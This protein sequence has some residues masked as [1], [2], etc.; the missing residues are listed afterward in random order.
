MARSLRQIQQELDQIKTAA[1]ELSEQLQEAYSRYLDVLSKSTQ[2]QLVLAGYHL[3]TQIYPETF[4]A[5]SLGQ[6][7]EMQQALRELGTKLEPALTKDITPEEL[8]PEPADLSMIAEMLKKLPLERLR[9]RSL[10]RNQEESTEAILETSDNTES[11]EPEEES[12]LELPPGIESATAIIMQGD[13]ELIV[14]DLQELTGEAL[15]ELA[16]E[17]E[18]PVTELDFSNPE[19]LVLWQKTLEKRIRKTLSTTSRQANSQLQESRI[20]PERLPAKLLD[21]ALKAGGNGGSKERSLPNIVNLTIE[22]DSRKKLKIKRSTQV[23][24]LRLKLSELEFA[25]PLLSSQRNAIRSLN[26]KVKQLQSVYQSKKREQAQAE[27]DA[28]WRS[29]WYED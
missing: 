3:C 9:D 21:V 5:L 22:N 23:S 25:D 8:A 4:L 13:D 16:S 1:S 24:L 26:K 12:N 18:P 15:Q 7:Q 2:K 10:A 29:S 20:L 19:H 28:A 17:P 11:E 27:A 14:E 6:R